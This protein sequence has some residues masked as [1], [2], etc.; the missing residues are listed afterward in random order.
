M[1]KVLRLLMNPGEGRLR[2]GWRLLVF[3][4]VFVATSRLLTAVTFGLLGRAQHGS[5]RWW[6]LRGAIVVAAATLSVWLVRRWVDRR[7]LGSLGLRLD[8]RALWDL[9]AGVAISGAM[10]GSVVVVCAV[11][12]L[13]EIGSIA[14]PGGL[15][16]AF[17][18][19]SLWFFAIGIA[20]AWSEEL[21]LRGYLLQNLRDGIGLVWAVVACC[22]FYGVVHMANPHSTLLSGVLI[23]AIG[24]LRVLGWLRTGQL[25]LSM[26]MHAGWDFLQG[27][28]L[29]FSV[30]GMKTDSLVHPTLSGPSWVTGGAFGPEAGIAVLPALGLGLLI[31]HVWTAHRHDTPWTRAAERRG[32]CAEV[33]EAS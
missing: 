5:V 26:G 21:A 10:V 15:S 24:Y 32:Y 7:S 13:I 31:M 23:V 17:V 4:L 28:V 30:S 3:V 20:V 16:R 33:Q 27:P 2:A 1:S 29:G 19:L 8:T 6:V 12:G 11:F 22:V 18:D 14:W 25:W 9:V